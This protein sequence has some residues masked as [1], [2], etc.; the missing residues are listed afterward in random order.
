MHE[1][2]GEATTGV[3]KDAMDDK[4]TDRKAEEVELADCILRIMDYAAG[5]GLDVAAA[6]LEKMEYNSTRPF[7]HGKKA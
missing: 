3:R 7:M 2:L 6:L 1:E 5:Y 4:L